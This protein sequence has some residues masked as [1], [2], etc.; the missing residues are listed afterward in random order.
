MQVKTLILSEMQTNC[1]L[2]ID[3][4][5][6]YT[7]IIDPAYDENDKIINTIEDKELEPKAIFITHGHFDHIASSDK[8]KKK[9]N[10]PVYTSHY[11]AINMNDNSL[12]LSKM[13]TSLNIT[14]EADKIISDGDEIMIGELKFKC[15]EVPGHS[16]QSICYYNEKE[17]ILF[18]GDTL[19]RNG[20]GRTDF[21][22]GSEY[23]L[24]KKIKERLM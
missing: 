14:A 21:Y 5:N 2:I 24:L 3:Q 17:K 11:E 16:K 23:I 4:N 20:V 8:L 9:Y 7:I 13:F 22:D 1:Y 6:K 18:S 19:F 12:N 15:I 10:I